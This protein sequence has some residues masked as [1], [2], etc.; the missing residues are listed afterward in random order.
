MAK[1]VFFG[2]TFN[3]PHIAHRLMLE[4]VANREDVEKILVIPTNLPPH[5]EQPGVTAS[6]EDRLSMCKLL[7]DGIAK[8]EVSDMEL[9]RGGKSYS[10]D[11]LSVLSL[12]YPELYMIIGG[13]MITSFTTW[14]RY[15]DIL[16]LCGI[17]AVRR[18]GV[19][20]E[21]FDKAVEDLQNEGGN[22][23]IIESR[24]PDVSSTE[25]RSAFETG[26]ELVNVLPEN[27]AEFIK[28]KGLY[29]VDRSRY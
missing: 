18:P 13:D 2:G 27:I 22:I 5:K 25:L 21:E 26:K 20:N 3:P 11:T 16:K 15:K 23:L 17:F 24:M 12:K 6:G 10:F 7:A 19:D 28:K 1:T 29:T 9:K 14:F 4:A 8:A